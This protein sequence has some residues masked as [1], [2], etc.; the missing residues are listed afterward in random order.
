MRTSQQE[1][2]NIGDFQSIPNIAKDLLSKNYL[3]RK[4]ARE[5]LVEIGKP[6]LDVLVELANSKDETVRW[7][8]VI[9]I[10]QI[11]SEETLDILMKALEDEEFSIRWLA[12]DGLANLGK[13]AIRP[14]LQ[15]LMDNPDSAYI[16]R[17]AHH[18]LRELKKKGV[19]KDNYALVETLANEFDHSNILLKTL[20]TINSTRIT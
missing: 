18:A 10:T 5:E 4:K 11:G 2:Y 15:K 7:E 8:A 19:F 13:Y 12:A 3:L 9:T 1:V 17:G 14:I 20:K 6:S 16:R